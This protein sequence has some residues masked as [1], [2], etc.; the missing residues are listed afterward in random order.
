ML[1]KMRTQVLDKK[2]VEFM[3]LHFSAH[4]ESIL[5]TLGKHNKECRWRVQASLESPILDIVVSVDKGLIGS[6][7]VNVTCDREQ[8]YPPSGSSSNHSVLR[9]NFQQKWPFRGCIKHIDERNFF[10]IRPAATGGADQWYPATVTKQRDDGRFEALVEM[11]SGMGGTNHVNFD[12]V[13]PMDIRELQSKNKL[14]LPERFLLLEVPAADP[15]QATLMIDGS[16][17]VTHHFA[18]P[19]P[20][21]SGTPVRS[22]IHCKVDKER[23]KVVADVGH[24]ALSRFLSMEPRAVKSEPGMLRHAWIVQIG[25]W[26]QHR[27]EIEKKHKRSKAV[28]VSVDGEVL[29]EAAPED[30]ECLGENFDCRFNFR[31]QHCI[32]YEVYETNKDG[33]T[34]PTKAVVAQKT[35][36]EVE[37]VLEMPDDRNLYTAEIWVNKVNFKS[38]PP[39]SEEHP[40]ENLAM[41]VQAMQM[42]FGLAVPYKV[43]Q[44]A[45]S[46]LMNTMHKAQATAG[47]IGSFFSKLFG[48][49]GMVSGCCKNNCS[50]SHEINRDIIEPPMPRY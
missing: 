19:T 24:V 11:P 49:N 7:Q 39:V 32:D 25:P 47:S 45:P 44:E 41:D 13:K 28:T 17:L 1:K 30:I 35:K 36:F 14:Q 37:V 2:S 12:A 10:E 31:G 22:K 5:T 34:L 42:S 38:L 16:D 21:P 40:E 50:T 18:R 9:E 23:K 33:E 27:I 6:P 15:L 4:D 3:V 8:V 43:N 26:A 20:A 29:V 46:G 48:T